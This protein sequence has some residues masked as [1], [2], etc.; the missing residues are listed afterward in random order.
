VALGETPVPR[1]V[2]ADE[3]ENERGAFERRAEQ[4]F[5]ARLGAP[6]PQ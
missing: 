4:G 6:V 3:D 1:G 5:V 2:G